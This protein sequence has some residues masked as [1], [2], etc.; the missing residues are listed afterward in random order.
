M[1][2]VLFVANTDWYLYNF[3]LSLARFLERN[4]YEV[5]FVC[6]QGAYSAKLQELG[7][8]CVDWRVSRKIGLPWNEIASLVRLTS[9]YRDENPHI[10]HV[11]TL[12]AI[13]YCCLAALFSGRT[14]L[15]NSIAGRG[16]LY[17]SGNPIY[18]LLSF[19]LNRLFRI[20]D[21][22]L[23]PTW[24]FENQFD[25]NYF[26]ERKLVS[27][28]RAHLVEGVG[29]DTDLFPVVP[30]PTGIPQVLYAG[31]FL[32]SKGLG[33]LVEA[34]K[35]IK[36][37]GIRVELT[38]VGRPDQGNPDTIGLRT[39]EEWKNEGL[40]NWVGWQEEPAVWYQ[41]ANIFAFP[42]KYGEGVPTVLLEAASSGRAVVTTN[43]PG[44]TAVVSQGVN[45][46]LVPPGDVQALA[47]AIISLVSDAKLRAK[48]G[49]A[50][51][52]RAEKHFSKASINQRTY[53]V[54]TASLR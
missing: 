20:I 25:F 50:G 3:R 34:I 33:D 38:L 32:W 52:K 7:F 8:R 16:H 45:G 54:Y 23:K 18:A 46:I 27:K 49:R 30:E 53:N 21:R 1:R 47:E 41:R 24:I 29:V 44:C 2:K 43:H 40:V 19:V 31:R 36:H 35:A 13:L 28:V 15:I 22:S 5:V 14:R 48:M 4:E 9:I 17:S 42:T 6:P 12:K 51:R 26:V 11:H 37:Q 10:V 39:L